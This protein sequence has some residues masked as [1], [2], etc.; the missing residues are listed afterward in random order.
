VEAKISSVGTS[1]QASLNDDLFELPMQLSLFDRAPW[2]HW[3]G[4]SRSFIQLARKATRIHFWQAMC[5]W[6]ELSDH[7]VFAQHFEGLALDRSH[8]Q[9]KTKAF[10]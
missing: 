8:A 4:A 6:L 10:R 1:Q 5:F 7:G 3:R 2:S 9:F